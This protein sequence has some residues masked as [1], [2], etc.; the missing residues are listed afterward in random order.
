MHHGHCLESC[1]GAASSSTPWH[2]VWLSFLAG[3]GNAPLWAKTMRL[4]SNS[5]S[6]K[7][8]LFPF[9]TQLAL[10]LS[11]H[12]LFILLQL[13]CNNTGYGGPRAG[14][15]HILSNMHRKSRS[16]SLFTVL[17]IPASKQALALGQTLLHK[18]NSEYPKYLSARPGPRSIS[19]Y[20]LSWL[21]V[22]MRL[23]SLHG[24]SSYTRKCTSRTLYQRP[25]LTS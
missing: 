6:L 22:R 24:S 12:S 18:V 3:R 4:D 11:F 21:S 13:N 19:C 15:I 5:S 1:H 10:P 8:Y 20:T 16:L 2:Q 14:D 23:F 17:F 25:L 9:R 7:Y